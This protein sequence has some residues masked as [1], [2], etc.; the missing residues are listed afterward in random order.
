[1]SRKEKGQATAKVVYDMDYFI[2]EALASLAVKGGEVYTLETAPAPVLSEV[3]K[4]ARMNLLAYHMSGVGGRPLNPITDM[5]RLANVVGLS[6]P[7]TKALMADPEMQDIIQGWHGNFTEAVR[8]RVDIAM[9]DAIESLTDVLEDD[10]VDVVK[11]HHKVAAAKAIGELYKA[12]QPVQT[13]GSTVNVQVN[14]TAG[15]LTS[16]A[17][18]PETRPPERKLLQSD[19]YVETDY[20]PTPVMSRNR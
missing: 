14:N 19:E 15:M 17:E 6:V 4:G 20:S 1:M 8:R 11:P 16:S 7:Q 9:F 12:V 5:H 10:D 13:G 2:A 18:I 3:M